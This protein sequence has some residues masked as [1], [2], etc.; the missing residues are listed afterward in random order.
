[1]QRDAGNSFEIDSTQFHS[2]LLKIVICK[3]KHFPFL[4]L[5]CFI[6]SEITK[7]IRLKKHNLSS[8]RLFS[9][10]TLV[11]ETAQLLPK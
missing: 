8:F 7:S 3:L 5:T 11:P 2:I 1:M 10:T 4:L 6:Y 9:I